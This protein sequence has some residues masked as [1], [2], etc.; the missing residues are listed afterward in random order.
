MKLILWVSY[1]LKALK[2]LLLISTGCRYHQTL[3]TIILAEKVEI[4][5]Y[6]LFI[7]AIQPITMNS[8]PSLSIIELPNFFMLTN[9]LR[10]QSMSLMSDSL[11]LFLKL[12]VLRRQAALRLER[13]RRG[14]CYLHSPRIILGCSVRRLLELW[15]LSEVALLSMYPLATNLVARC[16]VSSRV[17]SWLMSRPLILLRVE[18]V[19]WSCLFLWSDY[20][21]LRLLNWLSLLDQ[22]TLGRV[23]PWRRTL[24]SL[25]LVDLILLILLQELVRRL[26]GRRNHA[27]L[28]SICHIVLK[29]SSFN[30]A[31]QVCDLFLTLRSSLKHW[32]WFALVQVSICTSLMKLWESLGSPSYVSDIVIWSVLR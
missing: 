23:L 12:N 15:T 11:V 9:R 17:L 24:L 25:E 4:I 16:L 2:S 6:L 3:N 32:A 18:V 14:V 8:S 30:A 27:V 31:P 19:L 21:I 13:H 29:L 1:H 5:K 26:N 22:S 20:N 7:R 28:R 10:T